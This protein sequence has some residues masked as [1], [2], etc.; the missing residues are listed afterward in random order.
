MPMKS[1]AKRLTAK[2]HPDFSREESGII[3]GCDEAGRGPLAG[4]VTAACVFIPHEKRSHKI[5]QQVRDS[6][7]LSLEARE[8]MFLVIQ[9]QSCF[10]IASSSVVEIEDIN[11]LQASIL[12]M[13]RATEEM[14]EQFNICPDIV[15]IDGNYKPKQFPYET[16]AV[17]KGDMLSISI[18]AASILAKVTRDRVML[19]LDAEHPHYGWKS[20]SGYGTPV[21][22]QAL[23][24]HG[25]CEH[26]R[27]GFSPIK[28]L[29]AA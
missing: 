28:K 18:A 20:N 13:R 9:E 25:P 12:A 14:C 11:I 10:G 1:P 2:S 19:D 29:I 16:Q 15:L 6:K 17:I 21:H 27:R 8:E 26:H 4:P 7:V 23:K 22:L 24:Q 5:W 3:A